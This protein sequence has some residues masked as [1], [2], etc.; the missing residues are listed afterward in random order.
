MYGIKVI[1]GYSFVRTLLAVA[2]RFMFSTGI[3]SLLPTQQLVAKSTDKMEDNISA[4]DSLNTLL[5]TSKNNKTG[6]QVIC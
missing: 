1:S 3:F 2:L 4:P 6:W 5:K